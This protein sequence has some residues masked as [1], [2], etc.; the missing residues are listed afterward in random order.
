MLTVLTM[1]WFR[2]A[3]AQNAET[4]RMA[5]AIYN[6][7]LAASKNAPVV[8][9]FSNLPKADFSAGFNSPREPMILSNKPRF[10]PAGI[11]QSNPDWSWQ[12][13]AS[14]RHYPA[15]PEFNPSTCGNARFDSFAP[16]RLRLP[17]LL[18]RRASSSCFR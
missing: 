15:L 7:P 6:K 4:A 11:A 3:L 13:T 2:L 5:F 12:P 17:S 8:S 1:H 14:R 16:A 18:F 10:R 9:L